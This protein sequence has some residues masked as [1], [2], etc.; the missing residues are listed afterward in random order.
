MADHS[1]TVGGG[2]RAKGL[3]IGAL[4]IRQNRERGNFG[5]LAVLLRFAGKMSGCG[6]MQTFGYQIDQEFGMK[7][8]R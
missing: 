1:C 5:I 8:S 7:L 6:L 4:A 2:L 3:P